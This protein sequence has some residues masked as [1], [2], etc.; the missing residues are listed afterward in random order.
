MEKIGNSFSFSLGFPRGPIV[1]YGLPLLTGEN[2]HAWE[3]S[4]SRRTPTRLVA[5]CSGGEARE[6][7]QMEHSNV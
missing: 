3:S 2:P 7:Q 5:D 4:P 1:R 6:L